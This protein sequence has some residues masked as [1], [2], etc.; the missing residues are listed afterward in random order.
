LLLTGGFCVAGE[1]EVVI[2]RDEYGVPHVYADTVYGLF[3]G[4]G[5]AVAQDRLFMMEMARYAGQ[6]R[7]SEVLGPSYV[8]FDKKIRSLYKPASIKNQLAALSKKDRDVFRGYAAGIN[9][10]LRTLRKN[11]DRYMPKAFTAAGFPPKNWTDFDV[12]MVFVGSMVNRFGDFNT[13]PANQRIYDTLVAEHGEQKG[14]ALFNQLNPVSVKG[15]PTTIPEGEWTP[16]KKASRREE[17]TPALASLPAGGQDIAARFAFSNVVIAGRQKAEGA[18][19]ILMNGPQFGWYV[20]SYVYSIGLHGAGF[21]VVGN[22]PF[23]YPVILFGHNGRITW[24]STWGAGDLIDVYRERLHPADPEQYFFNGVYLPMDKRTE[25]IRVKNGDDVPFEVYRTIH[26]PVIHIDRNSGF[27]YAKKRAWEG[28][29]LETLLGWMHSTRAQNHREWSAQAARS[30]LN[31]NMYYADADGNIAYA[32]TGKYPKRKPGHDNR[33]PASGEGD[34]E[35]EGFLPFSANPQVVNPETGYLANWNNRPAYGVPN[36]DMF[37]Y[38]WSKADRVVFLQETLEKQ[39]TFTAGEIW[40]IIRASAFVDPNARYFI[41]IL[42]K[43]VEGVQDNTLNEAVSRLEQWN[44]QS[45]DEDGDGRYDET[46]TAVFRTFLPHMLKLTLADDLGDV[47]RYFASDGYPTPKN[48]L[49]SSINI[50]IGVK[51]IIEA[52]LA[53][54]AQAYDIFNGEKPEIT[55]RRALAAAVSALEETYGPNLD[56]W[57][58]PVAPVLFS[59]KNFLGIPQAQESEE[60]LLP[61]GMNRGTENNMTVFTA[62]GGVVSYEVTPP[63]Q[64][65]FIAKDG[66]KSPHFDDQ[67]EMY[68]NFDKKRVWFTPE[69]VDAHTQETVTL[70]Y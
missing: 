34:M 36:P 21:N 24:G 45:R 2:K 62:D 29:E 59:H 3:Y 37:W 67:L 41:P 49:R 1:N 4:Y 14:R 64:S 61:L 54:D 23:G 9:A 53:P 32:F 47:F 18:A 70:R 50:Q 68:K 51:C 35:W 44:Y 42:R 56:E 11:P 46:A 28:F 58:L 27:A 5:Y 25:T 57:K 26:G 40:E 55:A 38:S 6:G 43:A 15:A 13:E 52:V 8:D 66:T 60:M 30:A 63:G 69:E 17:P 10:W 31:I 16:P 20:P 12:A 22:T 7:V 33:L 19:S 39:E 48:P 65:A